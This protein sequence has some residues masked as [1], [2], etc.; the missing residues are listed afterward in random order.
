[1]YCLD[2]YLYYKCFV[3]TMNICSSMDD[4][5]HHLD[6]LEEIRMLEL[7]QTQMERRFRTRDPFDYYSQEEFT[8]RFRVPKQTIRVATK[9]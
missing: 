6:D 8:E 3:F 7:L 2:D 4:Y 9:I 1:M 5:R